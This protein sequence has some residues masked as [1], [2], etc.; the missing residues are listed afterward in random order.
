[1]ALV[2]SRKRN[3]T[4]MVGDISI[5]IVE[6]RGNKVRLAIEAP[7]DMPV[8]RL[9]TY[10]EMQSTGSLRSLAKENLECQR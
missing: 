1:M 6:I 7:D 3:E 4:I 5:T 9:E 2:L 10:L 8:H